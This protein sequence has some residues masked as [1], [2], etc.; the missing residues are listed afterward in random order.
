MIEA[1]LFDLDNCLSAADEVGPEL[2]EPVF[3]AVRNANAGTVTRETL[4]EAFQACWRLPFDDVA[5]RFGFSPAM[6]NAGFR[7]FADIEITGTMV[8]YSDLPIL[9]GA[10]AHYVIEGLAEL[11]GLIQRFAQSAPEPE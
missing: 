9:D 1:I 3:E 11:K 5:E 2:L 7:A 4:S 6:R 10:N 8:G